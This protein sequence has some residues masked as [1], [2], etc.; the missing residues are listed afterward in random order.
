MPES[1]CAEN[2]FIG[3]EPLTKLHTVNRRKMNTMAA[4]LMK[5][6]ELDI[7]V[8]QNLENYSLALQQMVMLNMEIN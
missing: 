8:T 3:R 2:L 6:L 7:D 4:E 5:S 1:F